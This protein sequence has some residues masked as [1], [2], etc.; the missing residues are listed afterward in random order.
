[1]VLTGFLRTP[2]S[3]PV[4]FEILNYISPS[5]YAAQV[6]FVRSP[7]SCVCISSVVGEVFVEAQDVFA[8]AAAVI[9]PTALKFLYSSCVYECAFVW[10]CV[11]AFASVSVH[12]VSFPLSIFFMY[13]PTTC[14]LSR[15]LILTY[16]LSL[17]VFLSS[18]LSVCL[19]AF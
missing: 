17:S 6:L 10:F 1:M 15:T 8:P 9:C 4:V 7:A 14:T 19:S 3:L 13:F 5:S 18:Y 12:A 2:G 16:T 11:R